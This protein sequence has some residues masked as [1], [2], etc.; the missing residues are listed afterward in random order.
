MITSVPPQDAPRRP[1]QTAR[2]DEVPRTELAAGL[3]DLLGPDAP[4]AFP[5]VPVREHGVGRGVQMPG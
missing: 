2:P 3:V 5:R 4:S 1:P